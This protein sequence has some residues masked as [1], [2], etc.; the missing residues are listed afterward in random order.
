MQQLIK[1][2]RVIKD[3]I[4]DHIIIRRLASETGEVDILM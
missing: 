3:K 4:V 2:A 1:L